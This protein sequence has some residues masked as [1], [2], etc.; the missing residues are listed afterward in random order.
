MAKFVLYLLLIGLGLLIL[1]ERLIGTAK[2]FGLDSNERLSLLTQGAFLAA[3]IYVALRWRAGRGDPGP[4]PAVAVRET[5][6]PSVSRNRSPNLWIWVMWVPALMLAITLIGSMI[7]E[8]QKR[9]IVLAV[10]ASLG[11]SILMGAYAWRV[12]G[13]LGARE[14]AFVRI[15][16]LSALCVFATSVVLHLPT[17]EPGVHMPSRYSLAVK[18]ACV[19][20]LTTTLLSAV[21]RSW[22]RYRADK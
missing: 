3:L 11:Y 16:V 9:V 20:I 6:E 22:A 12:I 21:T 4:R 18:W 5:R 2:S 19:L 13:A 8:D 7:Y 15:A 17:T 1:D 10:L 14:G